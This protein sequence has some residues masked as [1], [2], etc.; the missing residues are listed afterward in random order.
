MKRSGDI[1]F[2]QWRLGVVIVVG[3]ALFLWA[4][5]KGGASFL[6]HRSL[7]HARFPNVAGL[8][9]GSPVWFRGLEVGSVKTIA[10]KNV[11]DSSYV[12]IGMAVHHETL[13]SLH[14]DSKARIEAINFFGEKY[15]DLTPGTGAA[16]R[17][18]EGALLQ[19]DEAPELADL[20]E[21]GKATLAQVDTIARDLAVVTTRLREGRGSLGLMIS[22]RKLYDDLHRMT[23][24][25]ADLSR[26]L[27]TSQRRTAEALGSMAVQIDTLFGRMNRGQGTLGM[28]AADP[29]LY[30]SFNGAASSADSVLDLAANG[31]GSAG[32]VLN[33]P[34]LY[35]E[36]AK[37]LERLNAML[38]DMQKNPKKYFKFSM[39]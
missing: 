7:L 15:V 10:I 18:A 17:V 33:D 16:G 23:G 34:K 3:I 27:N 30:E 19:T 9:Q 1:P 4:S 5:I 38:L 31:K 2:G 36:L 26:D 28:L 11:G 13:P 39:F 6:E 12:E 20:M 32:R 21:K 22:D 8:S 25:V 24:E 14:A 35:D 29:R 37:S